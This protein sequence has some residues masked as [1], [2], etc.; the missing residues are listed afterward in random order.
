[1]QQME[2][3]DESWGYQSLLWQLQLF[4]DQRLLPKFYLHSNTAQTQY[5]TMYAGL[6]LDMKEL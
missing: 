2:F 1:M 4:K 5:L 3:A 6:C